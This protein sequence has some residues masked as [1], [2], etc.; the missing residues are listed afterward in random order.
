MFTAILVLVMCH[1]DVAICLMN[2]CREFILSFFLIFI[3]EIAKGS[4]FENL[5]Q[6]V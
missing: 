1:N 6:K 2:L 3:S 5:K 4:D